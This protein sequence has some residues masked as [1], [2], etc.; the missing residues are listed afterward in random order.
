MWVVILQVMKERADIWGSETPGLNKGV[1][2]QNEIVQKV[3]RISRG[4]TAE[5][6]KKHGP[7]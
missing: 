7:F 6:L 5:H 2:P 4:Q 1:G 3:F